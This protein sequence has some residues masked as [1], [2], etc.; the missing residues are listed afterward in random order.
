L[1]LKINPSA[2]LF[3]VQLN[4]ECQD[5]ETENHTLNHVLNNPD[6]Y[7]SIV[8]HSD[9][10][11][12]AMMQFPGSNGYQSLC[13]PSNLANT[14]SRAF[15]FLVTNTIYGDVLKHGKSIHFHNIISKRTE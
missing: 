2:L 3:Y 10:Q 11:I 12:F 9:V 5:S 1:A 14:N 6:S 13:F 4:F 7:I 15:S 8:W